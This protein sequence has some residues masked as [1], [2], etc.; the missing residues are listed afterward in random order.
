MNR[1]G[2]LFV[3]FLACLSPA[4]RSERNVK[5]DELTLAKSLYKEVTRSCWRLRN[6]TEV[7][8]NGRHDR[9]DRLAGLD[10]WLQVQGMSRDQFN[11][12][13]TIGCMRLEEAAKAAERE[14]DGYGKI[15]LKMG[16][17]VTS[18]G[19]PCYPYTY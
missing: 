5:P 6:D 3:I 16:V 1:I 10:D 14:V 17:L 18:T 19:D 9:I 15:I 2:L 8:C 11:K 13:T 4:S 12:T 7:Y